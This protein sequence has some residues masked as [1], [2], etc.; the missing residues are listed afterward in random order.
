MKNFLKF[1]SIFGWR[2]SRISVDP[3]F[4]ATTQADR[5]LIDLRQVVKTYSSPAGD[6]TALKNIDLQVK[7]GEF[8]AVIGKSGSGKSTLINML[9]GIDR[10]T[11][12]EVIIGGV[13]IHNL[14]ENL[15]ARWRKHN[16]G[17]IFQFFQLLPTLTVLENVVLPMEL[18]NVIP[19]NERE[20][21][22]LHLLELVNLVD[23]AHKFP[24]AISGGQ[25][26]RVAISR[27]LA[28][29]PDV[30]VAD[31][32]TGSLDSKTSDEIFELF[33]N[34]VG[35]GKTL[36]MVTHD[37][38]LAGRV[39]RIVFIADGEITDQH[40]AAALPSLNKK[41][42]A[43]I[44]AKL[45][46]IKY[47]PSETIIKQGDPAEYL[48]IIVKGQ[49]DVFI[50][51]KDQGEI[52][53]DTLASGQYFGEMGL[54]E[55]GKRTATV[56]ATPDSELIVMQLDRE[57]FL[58]L[59]GDSDKSKEE[60]LHL[61]R[62]RA[63]NTNMTETLSIINPAQLADIT[64][65]NQT[66]QTYKPGEIIIKYGDLADAF[67][68]ITSGQAEVINHRPNG[69]DMVVARLG[70]GKYFG[71]LGL[72]RQAKRMATVRAAT[73]SSVEVI[74]IDR[75]AFTTLMG[76]NQLSV[77]ESSRLLSRHY[78]KSALDD[79]VPNLRRRKRVINPLLELFDDE[80]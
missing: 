24:A 38:E 10:P 49:V 42:L 36:L 14:N 43:H 34:F 59:I 29:D 8:V 5:T 20:E 50:H 9:T 46:P 22:A 73:D 27:S 12:G 56:K 16:L 4:Q 44:S 69:T 19:A 80:T 72:I 68:I 39:P 13:P 25:Q 53:V 67:Y 51:H 64:A 15:M 63:M 66:K 58:K 6:F 54:L 79:F 37:R 70:S 41:E 55:G 60:M 17:V 48:Y 76:E 3:A 77:A 33:E 45:E 30:L 75:D 35:Q 26:Q 18:G 28:N 21:R 65:H 61:M 57:A 52:K 71:E 31:E 62:Q 74:S 23:Q 7:A 78:L 40:V 11:A 47:K 1:L 32:P 2:R